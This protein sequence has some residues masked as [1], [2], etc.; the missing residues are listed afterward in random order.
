MQ[1]KKG[2]PMDLEGVFHSLSHGVVVF[3]ATGS[4][5]YWNRNAET[6]FRV[7][8]DKVLHH[9]IKHVLP[10]IED[11]VAA[12]LRTGEPSQKLIRPYNK[13]PWLLDV[14]PIKRE[15]AITGVVAVFLNC[16]EMTSFYDG[17][18][19]YKILKY[20]MDAILD[21]SYDGL[22][23]CDREGTVIRINKASEKNNDLKAEDV[24]GKNIRDLAANGM[25]DKYVTQDVLKKK[26]SITMIQQVR[27]NKKL[28]VTGNPIF[29]EHGDIAYVLT[30]ERDISE[31]DK[32]RAELMERES[33][34]RS[35]ISKLTEV[36]M[37]GVDLTSVVYRS[38]EMERI[39]KMVLRL[40]KVDAAVLLLGESGVG[41][42]LIARLIHKNS[43]R[44]D[45]PFIRVD[46]TGIPETLLESELFGYERGAFTGARSEGKAGLF[47][48]ADRGTLFLDEIGDIPMSTQTKLLRF[49]E[50]HEIIRVGGV[51]SKIIDTRIIAAT[52]RN[53]EEMVKSKKFRR[54]LYYRIH[55]VPLVIP[56]LRE[57]R[58]DIPPLALHFLHLYNQKYGKEKLLLPEVI[59]FLGSLN[60]NGNVRELRHLLERLVVSVEEK[61]I[62]LSDLPRNLTNRIDTA[63]D[64]E[65]FPDDVPLKD[66][67]D[68]YESAIIRRALNRFGSQRLVAESLKVDRA[69]ISRKMKRYGISLP[70]AIL[71]E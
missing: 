33:L 39:L 38:R 27:G 26:T 40:G 67:V 43:E 12:C 11:I 62:A 8:E 23:I 5:C 36:E 42:G 16:T 25:F 32:L 35:Y 50:E 52:N 2:S 63:L 53:L 69:T 41:K 57:R 49:L 9:R 70:S 15:N 58:E 22:W 14:N 20:W 64:G 13:I 21:S 66:A 18:E 30:N 54:D 6:L 19:N 47:E 59:D 29:D 28:L 60:F 1:H 3:D 24:V 61:R 7:T 44:K 45:G 4:I 10:D 51:K 68:Q 17:T 56:P 37:D 46:C 71:H 55:V 34:T 65:N 48:L 31:M